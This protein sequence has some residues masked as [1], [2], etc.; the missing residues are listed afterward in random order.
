[1]PTPPK[2][3]LSRDF[4]ERVVERTDL[5]A[6]VTRY[7]P[8]KR[9]GSEWK[10][11]SPFVEERTPSFFVNPAKR[12]WKCFASGKGGNAIT[13]LMEQ[14]GYSYRDAVL[15]LAREAGVES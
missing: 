11:K 15:Q 7:V 4:I 1:M 9:A 14:A 5:V 6:L 2:G 10:G 13:F 12:C 8:L 3:L